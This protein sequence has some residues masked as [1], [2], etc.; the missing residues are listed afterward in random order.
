VK[1]ARKENAAMVKRNWE[2]MKQLELVAFYEDKE[3]K[4]LGRSFFV[5]K[6]KH[7]ER[8]SEWWKYDG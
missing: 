6:G 7:P 4:L 2:I 3:V 5:N 1:G 8:D